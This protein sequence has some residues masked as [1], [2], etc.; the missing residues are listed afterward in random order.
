MEQHISAPLG[1][2]EYVEKVNPVFVFGSPRSGTTL[3]SHIM[4]FHPRVVKLP[5]DTYFFK[6][7]WNIRN[8]IPTKAQAKILSVSSGLCTFGWESLHGEPETDRVLSETLFSLIEEGDPKKV[9]SFISYIGYYRQADRVDN[10]VKWWTER[11]NHYVFYYQLLKAWFPACKFIFCVRDPRA[12][13]TSELGAHREKGTQLSSVSNYCLSSAIDWVR[14]NEIAFKI[15]EQFRDDTL[16]SRYEDLVKAPVSHINSIWRF[17]DIREMD[18]VEIKEKIEGLGSIYKSKTGVERSTGIDTR[19]V[20]R[21]RQILS[22]IDALIIED[23]TRETA[24]AFGYEYEGDKASLTFY[25]KNLPSDNWKTWSKRLIKRL[26]LELAPRVLFDI[27]E[28]IPR[29]RTQIA[30]VR[31]I[32][33]RKEHQL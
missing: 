14:R 24:I 1:F 25:I 10:S 7:F 5:R 30:Y 21:W 18:E 33:I 27:I 11:C 6:H 8:K 20:E 2:D 31:N 16:I 12:V 3:T 17:L 26:L 13:I 22:P 19:S 23:V 15:R 32:L 28:I 9:F 29:V 4:K